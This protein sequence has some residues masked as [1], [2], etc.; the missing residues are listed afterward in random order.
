MNFGQLYILIEIIFCFLA[1]TFMLYWIH[2]ISHQLDFLKSFHIDHHR[3]VIKQLDNNFNL[4]NWHWNNL[5][6]FNDNWNSTIDLWLT[7]VLPTIV[8]SILIGQ[9]WI[10]FFYYIWAAFLQESIEHNPRFNLFLFTSGKWHLLHH[11]HWNKN[12]GLFFPIWD[13]VFSTYKPL[14]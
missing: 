12:Y 7:E 5:L 13:I 9:Y 6:L 11:R 8:F 3:F 1:W 2:R 14:H 4:L 10:L